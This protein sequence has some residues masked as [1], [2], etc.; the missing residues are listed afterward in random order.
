MSTGYIYLSRNMFTI[1]Q[2][3]NTHIHLITSY[4]SGGD[5]SCYIKKRG[6]VPTLEYWPSGVEGVGAP[7]FY[8]HPDSGGLDQNVVRSFS[9]QLGE[10][11]DMMT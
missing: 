11:I 7:A 6:Q 8:K 1:I 10:L 2:K 3:T 9:G 5:L 4:C